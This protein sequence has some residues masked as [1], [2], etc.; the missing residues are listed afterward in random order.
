LLADDLRERA[1]KGDLTFRKSE[2]RQI[3]S[4]LEKLS[5]RCAE[6]SQVVGGWRPMPGY[7]S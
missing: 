4:M 2:V 1:K 3:A 7:S 5:Y 6:A